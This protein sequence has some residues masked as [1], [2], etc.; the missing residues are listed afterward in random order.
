MGVY[1]ATRPHLP[2]LYG[3]LDLSLI[4]ATRVL[5]LTWIN[6]TGIVLMTLVLAQRNLRCE[7]IFNSIYNYSLPLLSCSERNLAGLAVYKHP[8]YILNHDSLWNPFVQKVKVTSYC[9]TREF[10]Y[11]TYHQNVL[12]WFWNQ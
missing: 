12:R 3:S 11:Y 1:L 2:Y 5:Q 4:I 6:L 7:N 9:M 8:P 10:L